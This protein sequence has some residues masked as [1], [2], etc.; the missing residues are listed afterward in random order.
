MEGMVMELWPI[1]CIHSSYKTSA[2]APRQ[3]RW[4][5]ETV[6]LEIY[7]AYEDGLLDIEKHQHLIILYEADRADR[8]R[9]QAIPCGGT[10]KTGVFSCRTPNRP[11]P[12]LFCVA[13]LID[14]QGRFLTV[15]GV[16]ALEGSPL[17]DI[18][19]YIA[20]LDERP[21]KINNKENG[22]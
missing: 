5:E 11:N 1:G 10:T 12:I 3:G 6:Q 15:R 14:R 13:E 16:E 2:D 18:K 9:L 7:E 8:G 17:L 22:K 21:A 20:A 4:S 19:P